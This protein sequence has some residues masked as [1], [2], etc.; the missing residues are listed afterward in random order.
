MLS[1]G[2]RQT[3]KFCRVPVPRHSAKPASNVDV[4][5]D[6]AECR[7]LALSKEIFAD[8][9]F[10]ERPLPS[11]WLALPSAPSTRQRGRLQLCRLSTCADVGCG[12]AI[13]MEKF[14]SRARKTKRRRRPRVHARCK[15]R[16]GMELEPRAASE[17]SSHS[18]SKVTY[19]SITGSQ[20]Q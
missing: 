15:Y 7:F 11:A 19:N 6:F 4:G 16:A 14:K 17:F 5:K 18:S 20:I 10:D 8:K 3:F 13:L 9:I 12:T 1:P 2:S